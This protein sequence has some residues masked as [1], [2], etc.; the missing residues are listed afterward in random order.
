MARSVIYFF[1]MASSAYTYRLAITT[2]I[3]IVATE[4]RGHRGILPHR[5]SDILLTLIDSPISLPC[6][7]PPET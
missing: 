7:E 1:A 6:R 4:T 3:L 2:G 5:A